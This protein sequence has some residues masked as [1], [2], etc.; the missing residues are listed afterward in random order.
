MGWYY[1]YKPYVSVAQ[2]RAQA[3][4]EMAQRRKKGLPVSP[5]T[6]DGRTIAKSFWGKAWCENLESYSDFANRLPRGRTYVRNGSVVHLEIQ[7]GKI[8]ADVAGLRASTIGRDHDFDSGRHAMEAREG[9][10]RGADRVVG[11]AAARQA[12]EERDGS[13]HASRRRAVPRAGRHRHEVL[14]P[15]F[16]RNVQAHRG[17]DVWHRRAARRAAGAAVRAAEGRPS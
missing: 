1:D 17:G 11:R 16:G 15:R 13:R 2:R 8:T 14:V 9:P 6:I 4:R 5:I 3:M 7:Q 12:L 10:V